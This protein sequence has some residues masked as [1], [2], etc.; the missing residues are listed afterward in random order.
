MFEILLKPGIEPSWDL[1]MNHVSILQN[2]TIALVLHSPR[3]M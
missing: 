2:S 1:E 3:K